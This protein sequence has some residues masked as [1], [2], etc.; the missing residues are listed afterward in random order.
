MDYTK[1][2]GQPVLL[3]DLVRDLKACGLSEGQTVIV[4]TSL[5]QLGWI[6]G[7]AQTVI[8][9]LLDVLG[10]TGTLVM[11]G[12]TWKNL[13]P[14]TGVHWE[15]PEAWWPQI[16]EHWPAYDPAITPVIGMGV[17]AEMFR[18]WPGTLRSGHPARSFCARG[19]QAAWIVQDHDLS[20]IFGQGSPLDKLYQRDARILLLGVGYDKNTSLHLAE[21][22]ATW[23]GKTEVMEHS[24]VM[25]GGRRTWVSY[26][27]L[28]VNDEDFT[29]LGEAW[30]KASGLQTHKVGRGT[31]RFM[32]QREL[33]DFAVTYMETHRRT[34][35]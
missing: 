8:Q 5:K 7:G 17:V 16:R 26:S 14:A 34:S 21:T 10:P 29:A 2:Q 33:V 13:D 18:T 25:T 31:A 15:V 12:Q 32:S 11:P 35:L 6:M 4:H 24:A 1:D 9:A 27:T 28:A 19:P 3:S 23:P 30:E 22:R 20:N